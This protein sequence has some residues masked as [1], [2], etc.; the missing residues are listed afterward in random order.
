MR[1]HASAR[2]KQTIPARGLPVG[3]SCDTQ[4]GTNSRTQTGSG[5]WRFFPPTR[6]NRCKG[7]R[8]ERE[9]VKVK[10][11][12]ERWMSWIDYELSRATW[13]VRLRGT[14]T[15]PD[16]GLPEVDESASAA[17][18]DLSSPSWVD[19]VREIKGYGAAGQPIYRSMLSKNYFHKETYIKD[20]ETS[21]CDRIKFSTSLWRDPKVITTSEI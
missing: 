12:N 9:P 5:S 18:W 17:R 8:R 20:Y 16:D 3:E 21:W 10:N 11:S 2:A 13:N 7:R 14:R 19:F 6:V 1:A 4:I 15:F